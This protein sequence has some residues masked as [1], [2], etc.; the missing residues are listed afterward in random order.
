MVVES[1]NIQSPIHNYLMLGKPGFAQND[2]IRGSQRQNIQ[3]Q[4]IMIV[5]K[6]YFCFVEVVFN[7]I[8]SAVSEDD[9]SSDRIASR[10]QTM[11]GDK[12][13]AHET[14]GS[15]SINEE[16]GI[17][18]VQ[19]TR[20]LEKRSARVEGQDMNGIYGVGGTNSTRRY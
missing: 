18:V 17:H 20:N 19:G 16:L 11:R 6:L 9:T 1:Q 5:P 4:R 3:V 8:T 14:G 2:L 13:F 12:R 10:A 15:P 7:G